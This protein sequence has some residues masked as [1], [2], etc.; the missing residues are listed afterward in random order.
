MTIKT[1]TTISLILTILVSALFIFS[2][3]GKMA[4][5]KEVIE[6][7]KAMGLSPAT[8]RNI[9]IIELIITLL[10]ASNR[11]GVIGSVLLLAY[12]GGAIAT[13]LEHGQSVVAPI[14]IAVFVGIVALF[15]FPELTLRILKK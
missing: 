6:G 7:A 14:A 10:F 12:M 3:V 13:H 8:M 9:G 11:T 1:K 15:R 5:T 2:A 4:G